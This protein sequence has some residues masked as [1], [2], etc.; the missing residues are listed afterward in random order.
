MT[1]ERR[2]SRQLKERRYSLQQVG[3]AHVKDPQGE[4]ILSRIEIARSLSCVDRP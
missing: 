2:H 4:T 1:Y 3:S